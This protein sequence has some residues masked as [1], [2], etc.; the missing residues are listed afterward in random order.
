LLDDASCILLLK[1]AARYDLI[2]ELAAL[3]AL[4]DQVD[5]LLFFKD[6]E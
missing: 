1:L 5:I 6:L 3:A 4:S 2:K